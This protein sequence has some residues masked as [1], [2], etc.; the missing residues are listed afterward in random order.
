MNRG[1]VSL[2]LLGG[3]ELRHGGAVVTLPLSAQRLLAFLALHDRALQRLFVAGS[4]WLD[5]NDERANASL[6]TALWRLRRL[7][8][9]VITATATH[10]A[11]AS[12]VG[13]DVHEAQA[14]AQRAL[15]S[16]TDERDLA[17]LCRTRE[18]LPDWYDEWVVNEREQFRQLRLHAL[19]RSSE[20]LVATRRYGEAL[21]AA[22]SAVADDPLRESAQRAL[23]QAYL[24]EGNQA[25]AVRQYRSYEGRLAGELGL[26]PSPLIRNLV[27]ALPA[28]APNRS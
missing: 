17:E 6:R 21:Q 12:G 28:S 14:R 10:V 26:R 24:A 2:K 8:G 13:T 27:A 20:R 1:R 11:L 23:I 25:E 7:D 18:L 3:F 4:L 16:D 15:W 5:S 19:E 9:R 22:L